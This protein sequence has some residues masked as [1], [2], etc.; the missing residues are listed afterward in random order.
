MWKV[1]SVKTLYRTD[2][3]GAPKKVNEDYQ[4]DLV[5]IEE[6][7]VTLKARTFDEAISKGEKE[8]ITYARETSHINPY[9]QE[10]RQEYIGYIDAFEPFEELA[11]NIEVFSSTFLAEKSLPKSELIARVA[12]KEYENERQIR[13]KFLNKKYSGKI[14]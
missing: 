5:L 8:A 11:P 12:G 3:I 13:I 6:R 10:V 2:T 1:Y 7:I 14:K 4:E 9:G